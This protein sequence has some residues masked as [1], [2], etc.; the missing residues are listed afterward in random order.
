MNSSLALNGIPAMDIAQLKAGNKG[1]KIQDAAQQFEALMITEM[2]KSARAAGGGSWLSSGEDEA[3]AA[4]AEM[5]EQQFAKLLAST[6]GVGMAKLIMQGLGKNAP[7][8]GE[9]GS[10]DRQSAA[11]AAAQ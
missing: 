5:A 10:E 7:A 9:V 11:A 6:G 2:M 1:G 3:G 8:V 4:L